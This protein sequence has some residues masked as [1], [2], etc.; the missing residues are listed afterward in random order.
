MPLVTLV[1][2]TGI[3][4][5]N[6]EQTVSV[7]LYILRCSD[8][9]YYTGVTNNPDRRLWEHNEGVYKKSYTRRRRPVEMVFCEAFSRPYDAILAEKQVSDW[10]RKKKEAL[11][12]GDWTAIRALAACKNATSHKV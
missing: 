7:Y 8:R 4:H 1:V 2:P 5:L 11:I 10:S 12:R 9:T 3:T 6:W